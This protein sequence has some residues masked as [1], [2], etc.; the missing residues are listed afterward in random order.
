MIRGRS[1]AVPWAC[2]L[3][4]AAGIACA[5]SREGAPLPRSARFG[6]LGAA[7]ATYTTQAPNGEAVRGPYAQPVRQGIAR[8]LSARQ[9]HSQPGCEPDARL[10]E[11]AEW[12]ARSLDQASA[13]P[14]YPV[15]DL[16]ARQLG[17]VEPTPHLVVLGEADGAALQSK[18]AAEI[19]AMLARQHY[20]HY[21]VA[22]LNHAS[23][24]F[25]VLVLSWRWL[26]L[27]PL[28]RRLALGAPLSLNGTLSRGL[29]GAQLVV[30]YPDG[31]SHRSP[32][33]SGSQIA[34]AVP[35]H[36]R[37]EHRVELLATSELGITVVANFPVYVGIEPAREITVALES[38][39]E[40]ALSED[41]AKRRFLALLNHERERAGLTALVPLP[42]LDSV[43]RAHSA[44]MQAH[45]FVGHTSPTTGSAEDRVTRAGLRSTLI[46][47]NIGRGYSP[48]EVHRGLMDSP[49][50]RANL[51]HPQA[52][53]VGLGVLLAPEDA[54]TA[55]LV[56][57][58]FVRLA[59]KVD[60]DEA[61]AELIAGINR[62]RTKRGAR[63]LERDAALDEFCAETARDFF[64]RNDGASSRQRLDRLNLKAR[65]AATRYARM[66]GVITVVVAAK[67]AAE[68]DLF[69]DKHARGIGLGLAQGTRADTVENAIA[70]VALVGY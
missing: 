4:I 44:D 56:T 9:H 59:R 52:T 33:Q 43:A 50:H 21:G 1:G 46:L 12:I 16:W 70:V 26:E 63:P 23:G 68:L 30:S 65:S 47:E 6:A 58:V 17:L 51:L 13:P 62:A 53:H 36:G 7:S 20:T 38:G 66:A 31:S 28:P 40:P 45:Q 3:L 67:D 8:A 57:Q 14:P 32:P 60:V 19:E 34:F 29:L 49:G 24:A 25:A 39:S 61:A 11:L 15:I 69:L 64:Q 37:G 41:E 22:T 27:R 54:R 2:C 55:Y 10:G 48:E 35:I 5:T 18:V 42:V